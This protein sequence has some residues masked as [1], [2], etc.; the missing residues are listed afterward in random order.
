MS[1]AQSGAKLY[2]RYGKWAFVAGASVGLG[3]AF[4]RE[5]AGRGLSVV[6][7]ARRSEL[8]EPLAASIREEF[9]V[10]ALTV[11]VDLGAP[12]MLETIARTTDNLEIGL[13]VYNA[14]CA[15][16]GAFL[17]RGIDSLLKVVDVNCR[18][19]LTLAHHFG[20]GMKQRGKG[21]IV[22]MSSLTA[23]NGS[24]YISTYGASKAFNLILGEGLWYELRKV[25][26]DVV[27]CCAGA[28]RTP[29]YEASA[30]RAGFRPPE[31]SPEEVARAAIGGLGRKNVVIR[32]GMNRFLSFVIRRVLSRRAGVRIMGASVQ[33]LSLDS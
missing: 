7:A 30:N 8:L 9:K 19:P 13:L 17:D 4:A 5:L 23:F 24:P 32:G 2:D 33:G 29:G 18:G 20:R 6:L 21:G 31:T 15:D 1:T 11:A 26:I 12:G 28:T 16:T 10:D 14:A 22:L 27:V 25:G 3:A